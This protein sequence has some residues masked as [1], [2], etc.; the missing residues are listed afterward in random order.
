MFFVKHNGGSVW[1]DALGFPWPKHP[2]VASEPPMDW[3]QNCLAEQV[4][5]GNRKVFGVITEAR[6]A[7]PDAGVYLTIR[8]SDGTIFENEYAHNM[9]LCEAIGGLVVLELTPDN[10][11]GSRQFKA[12]HDRLGVQRAKQKAE[13]RIR[14]MQEGREK[15]QLEREIM[16]NEFIEK[17]CTFRKNLSSG[18]QLEQ[19][20]AEGAEFPRQRPPTASAAEFRFARSSGVRLCGDRRAKAGAPARPRDCRCG[21]TAAPRDSPQAHSSTSVCIQR[22]RW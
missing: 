15:A 5:R 14:K 11:V 18:H 21:R 10:Q 7:D 1:F 9:N 17:I 6:T 16:R 20:A 2:C 19:A 12:V 3:L 22:F 13:E 8:C 4:E